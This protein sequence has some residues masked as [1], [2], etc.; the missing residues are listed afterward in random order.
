MLGNNELKSNRL[1]NAL[2]PTL[3]NLEN[4]RQQEEQQEYEYRTPEE[5]SLVYEPELMDE[6][7][8][9]G[10]RSKLARIILRKIRAH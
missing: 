1:Y 10:L 5:D 9:D 2:L 3:M 4:L 7:Y 8:D 6:T